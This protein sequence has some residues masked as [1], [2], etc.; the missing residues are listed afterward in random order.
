MARPKVAM[1]AQCN[2]VVWDPETKTE[3]LIQSSA[4]MSNANLFE[5]LVP[6]PSIPK[7]KEV[8]NGAIDLLENLVNPP[9]ALKPVTLPNP[10]DEL[11]P[12]F[13]V[14]IRGK[15]DVKQLAMIGGLKATTIRASD[16]I[17]LS[18]WMDKNGYM[19]NAEQKKWLEKYVQKRWFLTAFKVDSEEDAL[20]TNAVRL[21]FKTEVPVV[22]YTCPK[23]GWVSGIKQEMFLVSP[24]QLQ[25]AIGGKFLWNSR[26]MGHS[27]L[28]HEDSKK[29]AQ[30]LGV[31]PNDIPRKSWVTRYLDTNSTEA[32]V[33]DLYFVPMPKVMPLTQRNTNPVRSSNRK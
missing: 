16:V 15:V 19:A 6:T 17:A 5:V 28:N 27:F 24:V 20:K 2:M 21:S 8:G 7:V 31:S 3:H 4:F 12:N 32:A 10:E 23:N 11:D 30:S 18:D 14:L 33:D 13:G 26:L 25:G 29:F 22:P 9:R 1:V